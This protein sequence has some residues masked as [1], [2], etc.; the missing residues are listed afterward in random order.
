M[1]TATTHLTLEEFDQQYGH[2]SGWEYWFGEAV[3]KPVPTWYHAILQIVLSNLLFEA[4][5]FAGGEIDLKVDPDW[6][7]RPDVLGNTAISGRYPTQPVDIVIEVLS[8]DQFRYLTDKCGHYQR[9]GI[10]RIYV[11]DP[12]ERKLWKWNSDQRH[13]DLVNKIELP[14]GRSLTS[15][16]IWTEFEKR[17][18]KHLL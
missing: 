6:Q 5:Y 8:D 1:A 13:L 9:I 15:S 2:E 17:V 18:A 7:P 16:L 11:A 4:G 3:R 10:E 12:E 14:N